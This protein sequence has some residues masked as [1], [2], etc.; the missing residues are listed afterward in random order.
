MIGERTLKGLQW[1]LLFLAV[2]MMTGCIS[3]SAPTV[4]YYGLMTMEHLGDTE[5]LA[6]LPEINLGVGPVTPVRIASFIPLLIAYLRH[7]SMSVSFCLFIPII[8]DLFL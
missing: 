8:F 6:S 7:F 5:T 1:C 4:N 2:F 3:R